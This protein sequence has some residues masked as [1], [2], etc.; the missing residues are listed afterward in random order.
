MNK[1]NKEKEK[2][3]DSQ[4]NSSLPQEIQ[5][6]IKRTKQKVNRNGREFYIDKELQDKLR[7]VRYQSRNSKVARALYEFGV[8]DILLGVIRRSNTPRVI[9]ICIGILTNLARVEDIRVAMTQR[10]TKLRDMVSHLLDVI[11]DSPIFTKISVARF[12]FTCLSNADWIDIYRGGKDI[13]N[14]VSFIIWNST[15]SEGDLLKNAGKIAYIILDNFDE[16]SETWVS[17]NFIRAVLEAIKK[18]GCCPRPAVESYFLVLLLLST[19][20]KGIDALM[21]CSDGVEEMTIKYLSTVCDRFIP[22]IMDQEACLASAL[23]V[24]HISF[25][26]SESRAQI[27]TRD[28]K[29][30]HILV[31]I[32]RLV[33][34]E[35]KKN[36]ENLL[37]K[38]LYN[39]IKEFIHMYIQTTSTMTDDVVLSLLTRLNSCDQLDITYLTKTLNDSAATNFDHVKALRVMA[40]K[41]GQVRLIEFIQAALEGYEEEYEKNLNEFKRS[42]GYPMENS[43][44]DMFFSLALHVLLVSRT[45]TGVM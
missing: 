32:N 18:L 5:E 41:H 21:E 13:Q 8:V 9:V 16:A 10:N 38:Q 4:S 39:T 34:I 20:E 35:L 36:K 22:C 24:L 23:F 25:S 15:D 17:T 19:T 45:R 43:K 42:V 40:E 44:D 12:L 28:E 33:C 27:L 29:L 30:T 1:G 11:S 3:N 6:T 37:L 31:T 2:R 26:G 7:K 14:H